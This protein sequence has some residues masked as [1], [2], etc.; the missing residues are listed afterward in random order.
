MSVDEY[1]AELERRAGLTP[2]FGAA[3]PDG[4]VLMTDRNHTHFEIANPEELPE[5]VRRE[6]L[7]SQLANLAVHALGY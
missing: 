6:V 4:N 5:D 3:Q 2:L 1:F 7:E